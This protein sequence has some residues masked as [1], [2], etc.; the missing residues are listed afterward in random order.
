L[1]ARPLAV[2]TRSGRGIKLFALITIP[3]SAVN[4]GLKYFEAMV[5]LRFRKRLSEHVHDQYLDGTNFCTLAPDTA[6]CPRSSDSSSASIL[7]PCAHSITAVV[8]YCL[9]AS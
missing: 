7:V 4:A 2:A 9:S 3:A 5:S 1:L 6:A 8:L